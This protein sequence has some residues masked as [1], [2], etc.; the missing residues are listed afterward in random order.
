MIAKRTRTSDSA[1]AGGPRVDVLP[2]RPRLIKWRAALA[3]GWSHGEDIFYA[4]GS[5]TDNWARENLM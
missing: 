5:I 3:S 4:M 1:R 2:S